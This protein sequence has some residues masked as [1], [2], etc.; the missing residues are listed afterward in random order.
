MTKYF[1]TKCG[2]QVGW[3]G[4]SGPK[5]TEYGTCPDMNS[6]NHIWANYLNRS[7]SDKWQCAKCGKETIWTGAEG[8][9][10]SDY[11]KCPETNSKRHVWQ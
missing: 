4:P 9:G 3:T 1:C 2:K 10:E 11:G 5:A 6:G 8:P 7:K